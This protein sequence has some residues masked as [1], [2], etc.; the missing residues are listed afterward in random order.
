M[1]ANLIERT[2][3]APLSAPLL[4]AAWAAGSPAAR[5]E[6]GATR[7]G[8]EAMVSAL[9]DE[10]DYGVMLLRGDGVVV[11]A[12]HPARAEARQQASVHIE[13]GRLQASFG[14]DATRLAAAVS[15][16]QRG[17]RRLATL[18]RPGHQRELA[19]VPLASAP[20]EPALLAV[21]FG[22]SRLCEPIS[23]QCFAK[24]HSLTPAEARVL[25]LLCEGMDPR[26]IAELNAVGMATVRTQVHSIREK[27][28]TASIRALIHR[29]ALLPP[30][31]STLRC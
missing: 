16:A 29:V 6:G 28:G 25:E 4:R 10:L 26:E 5:G 2:P 21:V 30:M 27:T 24:T 14:E 17:L 7:G 23:V 3:Q 11:F 9:L 1:Q 15:A 31:V 13:D 19:F 22:R 20:G 18:G 12:N 8:L